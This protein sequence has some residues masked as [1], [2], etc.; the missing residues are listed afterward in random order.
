[1][2]DLEHLW[3]LTLKEAKEDTLPSL[4]WALD[5]S[6][7]DMGAGEDHGDPAL[8]KLI[9]TLKHGLVPKAPDL[10]RTISNVEAWAGDYPDGSPQSK[11]LTD[12]LKTLRYLTEDF[13]PRMTGKT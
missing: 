2:T 3:G 8:H 13:I 10:A 12:I 5:I 7:R 11:H 4:G 1:M 9:G 6:C